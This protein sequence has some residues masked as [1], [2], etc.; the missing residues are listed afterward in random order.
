MRCPYV[1]DCCVPNY[2]TKYYKHKKH[3]RE[4]ERESK[5]DQCVIIESY[6][7]KNNHTS[8][9]AQDQ[10]LTYRRRTSTILDSFGIG[11]GS[12]E[13]CK[14]I[15]NACFNNKRRVHSVNTERPWVT[16]QKI[17]RCEFWTVDSVFAKL[18]SRV[19]I[20]IYLQKIL[21]HFSIDFSSLRQSRRGRCMSWSTLL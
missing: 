6:G 14:Q 19:Y 3:K 10:K 9:Q 11:H 1:R 15:K 7:G 5:K 2:K 13:E 17:M 20:C 8:M 4:S 12:E 18:R 21:L 16:K